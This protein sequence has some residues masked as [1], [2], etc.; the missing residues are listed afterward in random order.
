MSLTRGRVAGWILLAL[1]AVICA[2]AIAISF[3][4]PSTE[5]VVAFNTWVMEIVSS[6][7]L[8]FPPFFDRYAA[9]GAGGSPDP[10]DLERARRDLE[11][12]VV[13]NLAALDGLN[14]PPHNKGVKRGRAGTTVAFFSVVGARHAVPSRG[15]LA[16]GVEE[17]P[18]R[19]G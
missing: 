8:A 3:R 6:D 18:A 1:A 14:T 4:I 7:D 5:A 15:R 11:T 2:A 9:Y 17:D 12:V 19:V 13:R 16:D 10:D